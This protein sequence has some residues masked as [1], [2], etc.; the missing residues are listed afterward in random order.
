ML[1]MSTH[2]H[3]GNGFTKRSSILSRFMESGP[4]WSVLTNGQCPKSANGE[5]EKGGK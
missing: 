3:T 1:Y 2:G 4:G 5:L